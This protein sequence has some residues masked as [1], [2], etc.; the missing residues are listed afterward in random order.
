MAKLPQITANELIKILKKIGFEIL[1]QSGSHVFLR[2]IDGR[3]T[4]VPNHPGEKLDRGLLNKILRKDIQISREKF[5]ELI[6]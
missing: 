6:E 4:V 2:H 5:E 3:T 1:R